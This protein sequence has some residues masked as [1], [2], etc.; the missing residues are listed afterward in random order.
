MRLASQTPRS[1][2]GGSAVCR[3][4]PGRDLFGKATSR[5]GRTMKKVGV[6][7]PSTLH[8]IFPPFQVLLAGA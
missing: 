4:E 1:F 2:A 8:S 7:R 6:V 3:G 5:R